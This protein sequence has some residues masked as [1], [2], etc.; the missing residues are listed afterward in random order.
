[1]ANGDQLPGLQEFLEFVD[2]ECTLANDPIFSKNAYS[3]VSQ[4]KSGQSDAPGRNY[5]GSR[6]RQ[7]GGQVFGSHL[8]DVTQVSIYIF[9]GSPHNVDNCHPFLKKDVEER[10]KFVFRR[11]L[12]FACYGDDHNARS[13]K[14]RLR[15]KEC[16]GSHPTGLHGSSKRTDSKSND[17]S[18]NDVLQSDAKSLKRFSTF[19]SW[20]K[21]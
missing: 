4:V 17:V 19:K 18:K 9:C 12:C 14:Q 16:N 13:C 10:K 11:R 6:R 7:Q 21:L 15:C 5:G 1:M 20:L 2:E 8:A 3:D